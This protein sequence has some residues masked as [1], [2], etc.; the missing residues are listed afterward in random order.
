MRFLWGQAGIQE[1][2]VIF[3]DLT[4]C[5]E[6]ICIT[7]T[8]ANA[9]KT[10]AALALSLAVTCRQLLVSSSPGPLYNSHSATSSATDGCGRCL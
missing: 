8:K 7:D 3:Y 4:L 2:I 10:S 6:R 5:I 9:S 1:P